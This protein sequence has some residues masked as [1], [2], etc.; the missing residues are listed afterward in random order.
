ML[1]ILL[2]DILPKEYIFSFTLT[3]IVVYQLIVF[4]SREDYRKW[5]IYQRIEQKI[6]ERNRSSKPREDEEQE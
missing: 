5:K 1:K 2:R 3:V 6:A 4:F